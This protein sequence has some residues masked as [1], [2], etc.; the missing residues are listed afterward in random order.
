MISISSCKFLHVAESVSDVPH[1]KYR[2]LFFN[3]WNEKIK[4]IKATTDY[5]SNM[6]YG[7]MIT[8]R[9]STGYAVGSSD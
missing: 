1:S 8:W 7:T 9:H 2:N 3:L 5:V 6:T 4:N